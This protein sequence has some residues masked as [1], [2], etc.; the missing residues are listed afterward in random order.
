VIVELDGAWGSAFTADDF[1]FETGYGA[2]PTG[3]ADDGWVD[4]PRP[5]QIATTTVVR[6]G[7]SLRRV[8]LIWDD[9]AVRNRWLRVAVLPTLRTGLAAPDVF[10]FGNLAGDAL[11]A[12]PDDPRATVTAA[13]T[14]ETLRRRRSGSDPAAPFDHDRDY[15][16]DDTDADIARRNEGAWIAL[17]AGDGVL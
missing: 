1:E 8:T 16:V 9:R 6:D 11:D 10:S 17:I 12:G 14:A 4:A 5:R 2:D 15:D 13:D 3:V 7:R